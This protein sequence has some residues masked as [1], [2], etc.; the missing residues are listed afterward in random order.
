MFFG[1]FFE[2]SLLPFPESDSEYV[3]VED[4]MEEE[5]EEM[6]ISV[7]EKVFSEVLLPSSSSTLSALLLV[8]CELLVGAVGATAE[9]ECEVADGEDTEG[10][11]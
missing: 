7:E 8:W 9:D 6:S 11:D 2:F 1:F 10:D 4:D 5:E 3:S